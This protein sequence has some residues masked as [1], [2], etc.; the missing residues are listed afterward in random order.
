MARPK[1]ASAEQAPVVDPTTPAPGAP[2]VDPSLP[3]PQDLS[4]A[5][6]ENGDD[7]TTETTTET[8]A[9]GEAP[10]KRGRPA[11][12]KTAKPGAEKSATRKAQDTAALAHQIKGLHSLAA[13]AT[14]LQIMNISDQEAG[15][16]ASGVNAVCE[17][18][19]FALTG[20]T[21]AALQLFAAAAMVYAPRIMYLQAEKAKQ[22]AAENPN[23]PEAVPNMAMVATGVGDGAATI[24]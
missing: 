21:G 12:S 20:K 18:Y 23:T 2:A 17:E 14:G 4:Q 3:P 22:K 13:M 16:L 11:G 15:I 8:A 10:R 24:N 7:T 5:G 9:P 19:G 1:K 6:G